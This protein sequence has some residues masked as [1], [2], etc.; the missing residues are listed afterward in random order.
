MECWHEQIYQLHGDNSDNP[1]QV[2]QSENC[3]RKKPVVRVDNLREY[4]WEWRNK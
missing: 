4:I 2:V 3:D 1:N